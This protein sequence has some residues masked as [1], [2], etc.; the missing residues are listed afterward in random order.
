LLE[1]AAHGYLA[2]DHR[3]L[4]AILD[5][6]EASIPDLARFA[7]E[8]RKDDAIEL[9]DVLLDIFRYLRTPAALPFLI[10][11]IRR[12]VDDVPDE[13]VEALVPLGAAAIDPLL[14]LL[15]D[16]EAE[17][18]DPNELLFLL[19]QLRAPDARIPSV[20]NQQLAAGNTDAA[21]FLEMYENTDASDEVDEPF[22]IWAH[23][24]KQDDAPLEVLPNDERL[25]LLDHPSA[26][27]RIAAASV[28]RG[29][30]QDDQLRARLL[31]VAKT[32]PDAKVR[33]EAW[34][35]LEE[36]NQEPEM[37]RAMMAA[38][39]DGSAPIEECAG[40]AVALAQHSDNRAVFEAIEQLYSDPSVRAKALKAMGRSFDKRFGTY[41]PRHL[42][43]PDPEIKR[44]AI[45]AAGYLS[46]SSEASRL[47]AF[48]EDDEFR[49]DALFAYALA[50]PGE[51]SRSR[52]RSLLNKIRELA[53]GFN[54]D[55]EELVE[56]ALDQRLVLQ[57]KKPVFSGEPFDEEPDQ[58]PAASAK[59]GRNDPCPCGSGK[60]YK[61]CCG[62]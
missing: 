62:A 24:P 28:S 18:R 27:L 21:L 48:F 41:P 23:Y 46:L 40:A 42:D 58:A 39:T 10:Q 6:S 19:S 20:L 37:R 13:L 49:T 26:E 22:D 53:G 60:K 36:L 14:G 33:G 30:A 59:V 31:Q 29:S 1:S 2:V 11:L 38:L 45:W 4:H 52:V 61:K 8:D 32:D 7:A 57:G 12:Q 16:V 5:R 15:R 55:E 9:D 47:V 3:F 44:Q 51:I 56:V 17:K 50:V 35:S 34:E 43:D 54:A 25:A